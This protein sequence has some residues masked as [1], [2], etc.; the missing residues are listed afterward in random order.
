MHA[1]PGSP[2]SQKYT[3]ET[4]KDKM[5][6]KVPFPRLWGERPEAVLRARAWEYALATLDGA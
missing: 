5:S 1:V 4:F 3:C 2:Q 6:L